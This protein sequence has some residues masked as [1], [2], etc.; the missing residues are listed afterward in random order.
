MFPKHT[1]LQNNTLATHA[2][3][4]TNSCEM[5]VAEEA[6]GGTSPGLIAKE[7]IVPKTPTNIE[8]MNPGVDRSIK[9]QSAGSATA[10]VRDI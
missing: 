4:P 2:K 8:R 5:A 10:S 1:Q 9:Y 6:A 7:I 3:T